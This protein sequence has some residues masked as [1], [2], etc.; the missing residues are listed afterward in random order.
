MSRPYVYHRADD[1]G[2][3]V[4]DGKDRVYVAVTQS[5]VINAQ[6]ANSKH[7]AFSRAA[8]RIDGVNA[9]YFFRSVAFLEYADKI[10]KFK[11]PESAQREIVSFDRAH[12]FAPGVYQLTPIPPSLAATKQRL[13]RNPRRASRS[14]RAMREA[15]SLRAASEALEATI[16]K[17][18]AQDKPNDTAEQKEFDRRLR[19]RKMTS[20]VVGA[21]APEPLKPHGRFVRRTQYVRDLRDPE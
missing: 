3:P 7:C 20:G 21:N 14:A 2:I 12:I 11:L 8:L 5:D 9:A 1:L 4:V 19:S 18:A 15:K 16:A 10:V 17:V 6:K 13:K